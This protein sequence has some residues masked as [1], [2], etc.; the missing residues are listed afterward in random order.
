MNAAF[1]TTSMPTPAPSDD[2]RWLLKLYA[3]RAAFS[4]GWVALAFT[5]APHSWAF[6][7]TLLVIYPAWDAL[8]N[9]ADARRSGG[10]ATNRTQAINVAASVLAALAMAVAVGRGLGSVFL[11][12]GTWAIVAGLM[13][14]AT[15]IGRWKR[16]GA[17]WPM[18]LSGLQSAV[19]GGLFVAQAEG[20]E[21]MLQRLAGYA[22]VGALYFAV[23]AVILLVRRA[24]A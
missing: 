22:A 21:P 1:P 8:A 9:F 18:T 17:Q 11:V 6:A 19:A 15:A 5:I 24:R 4:L 12:F 10:L 23:S 14:L 13:Q 7:G 3:A 2:A 16:H 20:P